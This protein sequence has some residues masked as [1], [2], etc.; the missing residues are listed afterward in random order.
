M[1]MK[2]GVKTMKVI[3]GETIIYINKSLVILRTN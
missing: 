1:Y 2:W 3:D